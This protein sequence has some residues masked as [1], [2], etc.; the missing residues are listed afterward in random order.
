LNGKEAAKFVSVP[1]F[2]N[3]KLITSNIET[4]HGF[5]TPLLKLSKY[6]KKLLNWRTTVVIKALPIGLDK[7]FY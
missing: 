6:L 4:K 5:D 7:K 2:L 1:S 3:I